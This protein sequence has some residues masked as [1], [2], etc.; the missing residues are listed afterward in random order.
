M[1]HI[2]THLLLQMRL[3]QKKN[4]HG[5]LWNWQSRFYQFLTVTWWFTVNWITRKF[6]KKT[7]KTGIN[8]MPNDTK[9]EMKPK[10]FCTFLAYIRSVAKT[11]ITCT[12]TMNSWN[13][14]N[15]MTN[16][17]PLNLEWCYWGSNTTK[18]GRASAEVNK[19]VQEG[20]ESQFT[21]T[22]M[23]CTHARG[24][25]MSPSLNLKGI[26]NKRYSLHLNISVVPCLVQV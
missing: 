11:S 20:Q 8:C 4:S 23:L 16:Q 26:K 24:D 7:R 9:E 22:D 19:A 18:A 25:Y 6:K 12:V 21:K 2:H 15:F 3:V 17:Y 14:V 13:T 5:F 1:C 10:S